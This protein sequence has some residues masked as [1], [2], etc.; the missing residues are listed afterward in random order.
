MEK[1]GKFFRRMSG[2]RD[3]SSILSV[4]GGSDDDEG[5][6]TRAIG[7]KVLKES[8]IRTPNSVS[9]LSSG[10]TLSVLDRLAGNDSVVRD[11]K[12]KEI[13]D[14]Q[15]NLMKKIEAL[16]SQNAGQPSSQAQSPQNAGKGNGY[17]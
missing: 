7:L 8:I 13:A 2:K 9:P 4:L 5:D 14:T 6:L 11:D 16:D 1:M 15:K 3:Q 12:L 10:S 17:Q